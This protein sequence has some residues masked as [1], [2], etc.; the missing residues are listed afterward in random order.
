MMPIRH[1][2]G[3]TAPG[4]FGPTRRIGL[5]RSEARAR[6]MSSTGIPSVMQTASAIPPSAASRIA[7]AAPGGGTKITDAFAPVATTASRTVSKSGI[8]SVSVAPLPGA[9]PATT[10]VP[11]SSESLAWKSPMRP[12]PWTRT[13]VCVPQ[14]IAMLSARRPCRGDHS[15]GRLAQRLGGQ[16]V[17]PGCGQDRPPRLRVRPL[18]THHQRHLEGELL[19]GGH[20][21][22]RDQVAAHDAA[23]DVDEDRAHARV[24]QDQ[25]EGLLHLLPVGPAAGVEEIRRAP[26]ALLDH[27]ERGHGET[28][29]VHHAADVAVEPDVGEVDLLGEALA[30]ILLVRVAQLRDVGVSVEC[31][32]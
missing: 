4:Q 3:V 10:R 7:S 19:G 32:V 5:P 20:H 14:R 24:A 6:T 1:S 18:Q 25:L 31:A 22:L 23:E 28:R 12:M 11:Y 29:A 2:P 27:V 26:T 8:P 16:E 13:C 30:G 9:T 15:L 21:A 17:E